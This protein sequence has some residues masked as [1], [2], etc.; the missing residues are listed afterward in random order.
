MLQL[1]NI[2]K[3]YALGGTVIY[4]LRDVSLSFRKAEFVSVL[5][6]SGCGKTTMLNIIGGLDRYDKAERD[7]GGEPL[8]SKCDLIINGVSTKR[9]K[10][11]D[12]DAYRNRSVGFVFQNYNL[13]SHQSVLA[14]VEIAMTLSGVAPAERRERAMKALADVGLA[15]QARK[16]P[17]Q[18]SGGQMQR[19]AIARALVNNPE[20]VMADEP[21]GALDTQTSVQI[22]EILRGVSKDRLVIMVTH[23]SEMADVYS[24]RIVRL[25]DGRVVGDSAPMEDGLSELGV[26]SEEF[27]VNNRDFSTPSVN[28]STP[29]RGNLTNCQKQPSTF[30]L[31]LSTPTSTP[32]SS[33]L[34]PHYK[35]TSMSFFTALALSFKNLLTKK[36]RTVITAIAGS[37]GIIGVSLVLALSSGVRAQI[38]KMQAESMANYPVTIDRVYVDYDAM[39][40]NREGGRNRPDWG[41]YPDKNSETGQ[42]VY[43]YEPGANPNA[44]VNNLNKNFYNHLQAMD[45]AIYNSM[46]FSFSMDMR[47]VRLSGEGVATGINPGSYRWQ[48]LAT[49]P[50]YIESL[51]DILN[52]GGRLPE[53]MGEVALV[54]DSYNRINANF[55]RT[56]GL[57]ME[58][59]QESAPSLS[60]EDVINGVNIYALTNDAYYI[61]DN[62]FAGDRFTT[63]NGGAFAPETDGAVK[64]K[65]TGIVRNKKDINSSIIGNG[66]VYHHTLR[67][68]IYEKNIASDILASQQK[69][70]NMPIPGISYGYDLRQFAGPSFGSTPS[71][72]AA[73]YASALLSLGLTDPDM[74][75][76]FLASVN[77]YPKG[78]ETKNM[79]KA[80][81]DEYND[82]LPEDSGDRIF[83]Q[84]LMEVIAKSVSTLVDYVSIG[85]ACFAGVSLIVSSIMIG[86]ITY[87][88]VIERTKEIG[89]LRS[90]GARKK[91]ISR[92]F[93]AETTIIGF[94]AGM[95]GIIFAWILTVPVNIIVRRLVTDIT[96]SNIARLNIWTAG[97][98]VLLSI[99]L[100]LI[101]G[102]IPSRIA[103]RRDPVVA[104][105]TE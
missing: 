36:G 47:L 27:G 85:L 53:N 64:L 61:R 14:N 65:I 43:A 55:L 34:T 77:I 2:T 90:V 5:G 24:T 49:D 37:I 99:G 97:L 102:F 13:I 83:Y 21:T 60:F 23:N 81:I 96:I 41:E 17:N 31:Q 56:L 84:D 7:L 19:V 57:A 88:S 20:I 74:P 25:L 68:Y 48:E 94:T 104:L 103:A 98:M 105:R 71:T 22:M 73:A 10:D 1:K 6:P 72:A 92:V 3:T 54:V 75:E 11:A 35:R 12:W 93:N 8:D 46:R 67:E 44:G 58:E 63:V 78:F 79:V 91:D 32:H 29:Q 4:A 42:R 100:T 69:P 66:L 16:K 26:G 82:A 40:N 30:N 95:I 59:G 80:Y 70:E 89:I 33:L 87:V 28:A 51:Y 86:I 38:D 39:F 9:F 52:A 15:D 76:G 50:A 45:T 101:A 18:L 62:T